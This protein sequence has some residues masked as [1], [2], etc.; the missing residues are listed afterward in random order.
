MPRR[1]SSQDGKD[2]KKAAKAKPKTDEVSP[3][4]PEDLDEKLIFDAH[5]AAFSHVN[6]I[7]SVILNSIKY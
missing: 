6:Y 5:K 3:P 7:V 4:P 1:P 2:T